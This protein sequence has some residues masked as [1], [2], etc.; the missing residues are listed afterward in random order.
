M[1]LPFMARLFDLFAPQERPWEAAGLKA[2]RSLLLLHAFVRTSAW[3]PSLLGDR[4]AGVAIVLGARSL[5]VIAAIASLWPRRGRQAVA[6]G[7]FVVLAEVILS[8]PEIGDHVYLELF[9]LTLFVLLDP[10]S[11]DDG[12]LLRSTL[13]WM[14]VIV[15]FHSGLQKLSYG[16]YF[17]AEFPLAAIAANDPVGQLFAWL[18]P[19]GEV[20]RL[21]GLNLLLPDAGPFRTDS[22]PLIIL[23]NAVWALEIELA[24]MMAVPGTRRFAAIAAIM[25]VAVVQFVGHQPMY[26][27]LLI[28]FFLLCIP[29]QWNRRLAFV[30]AA[31][32]VVVFLTQAG[33][34]PDELLVREQRL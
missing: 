9:G 25:S 22:V 18:V 10:E 5:L 27:L 26:A 23:S 21:R 29:G 3:L 11:T 32:Y 13:C 30:L 34:L 14:G 17:F 8:F 16:Y 2:F 24:V 28:Q 6:L 15:L 12:P 33:V 7:A 1:S 19:A 4:N 31:A 20:A